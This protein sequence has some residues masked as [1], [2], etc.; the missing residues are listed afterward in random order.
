M[1]NKLVQLLS[2]ASLFVVSL[3]VQADTANIDVDIAMSKEVYDSGDKIVLR[4]QVKNTGD[5]PV[6][7]LGWK[8]PKDAGEWEED[9]F[10]IE[11]DGQPVAYKGR[12]VKRGAVK[13]QDYRQLKPGQKISG[14][15]VL[16][17]AYDFADTGYY[18][19]SYN[20]RAM[21]LTTDYQTVSQGI[22][23][24]SS[25]AVSVY[26]GGRMYA[27]PDG[28]G[29]GDGGCK[30]KN[31]ADEDGFAACSA[32]QKATVLE[33]HAAS[34]VI[35]NESH[36]YMLSASTN[37]QRYAKWFGVYDVNRWNKVVDD[38]AATA[39]AID[40]AAIE[41]NCGCKSPYYAYVYADQPYKITLCRDFWTAPVTGHNSMAST[42]LHEVSHFNVVAGTDDVVYG[43]DGS[44]QLAIDDPDAAV[45]NADNFS[46]FAENTPAIP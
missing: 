35:T 44:A 27:K 26:V 13:K 46:Y 15:A 10:S 19:I 20:T 2:A 21:Y 45:T 23:V 5:T 40:N 29:G 24:L 31:C 16:S 12:H 7:L 9:V 18:T 3:F 37:S 14:K 38:F 41:Y 32:E 34:S 28:N 33:A 17:D 30:G 25:E 8:L 36:D 42:I 1:K 4:Y 6:G 22:E 43:Y 11:R 39:N